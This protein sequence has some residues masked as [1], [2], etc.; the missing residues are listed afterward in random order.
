MVSTCATLM[1]LAVFA[2]I[3]GGK[4]ITVNTF[5][6]FFSA[7]TVIHFGLV[8]TR[9]F[10]SSYAILEYLLDVSYM[11]IVL[12]GFGLYFDWFSSVPVWYFI[13]MAVTIYAFGVFINIVRIKKDADELNRLLQKHKNKNANIVT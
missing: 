2:A 6:F 5:F 13:V 11:M 10:E 4:S 3:I 1:L 9:K 7:N 8:L 12:I